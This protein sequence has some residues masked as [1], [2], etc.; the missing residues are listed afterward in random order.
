MVQAQGSGEPWIGIDLGTTNSCVG[1]WRNGR[2]EILQNDEGQTTTP[3]VVCYRSE[4]EIAVG[5]VA[6]N[7][8]IRMK[9]N[10]IY[11][12]KRVIGRRFSDPNVTRD[13]RLWPFTLVDDGTDKPYFKINFN[14]QD[15]FLRPEQV[16]A[17]ILERMK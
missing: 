11:D 7:Q 2:V 14:G 6:Q 16:S 10:T 4:T 1:L 8:G 12:S 15:K 13:R 17:K 9:E 5:Q 3:S